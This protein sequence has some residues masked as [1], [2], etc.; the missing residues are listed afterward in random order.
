MDGMDIV[1]AAV[2]K[3][4]VIDGRRKN[5]HLRGSHGAL[6][7]GGRTKP[8]NVVDNLIKYGGYVLYERMYKAFKNDMVLIRNPVYKLII[9]DS[10][11][12]IMNKEL[13]QEDY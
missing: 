1:N 8:E 9:T 6:G 7:N 12:I 10:G 5:Y 13:T 4:E 2:I 3:N 11:Y